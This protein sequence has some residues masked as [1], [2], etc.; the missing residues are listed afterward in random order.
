MLPSLLTN[1]GN[2]NGVYASVDILNLMKN[3]FKKNINS[4]K[5][6]LYLVGCGVGIL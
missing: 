4:V 6:Q 2:L 3:K 5:I 1:Y